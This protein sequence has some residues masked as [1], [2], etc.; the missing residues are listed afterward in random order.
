MTNVNLADLPEN[1]PFPGWRGKFISSAGMTFVYWD[2]SAGTVLP[3]HSHPHEQVAHIF[4]GEFEFIVDG[5]TQRLGPGS[6][7]IVPPHAVHSGRAITDC[8]ILDVFC[9]VREDYVQYEE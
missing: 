9:P 1:S 5:V 3:G 2:V 6:V 8:R 4:E 7:S